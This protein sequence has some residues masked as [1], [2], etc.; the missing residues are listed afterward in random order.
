MAGPRLRV[1]S[2]SYMGATDPEAL[3]RLLRLPN[4]E[5]RVSYDTKRT[6]LHAKAYLVHRATNFG[7]AYVGSAN[8]SHAALSEG[9]EWTTKISHRELPHLWA[10]TT[11]T[12]ETYW[13]DREFQ[14]LAEEGLPRLK[15]S[16]VAERGGTDGRS[17][18]VR[19]LRPPPVPLSR[20]DPRHPSP[21]SGRTGTSTATS[22][23]RPPA[24]ARPSSPPL[25]TAGSVKSTPAPP[26]PACS[27]SPTAAR[28]LTRPA[29]PSAPCSATTTSA[30]R[31]PAA[32]PSRRGTTCFPRSRASTAA[33]SRI[34]R[35]STSPTSSST[36]STTPRPPPTPSCS[37]R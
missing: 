23:S 13:N 5:V 28:S 16:I 26:A 25:T 1:I 9:L 4:A 27:S 21:P 14:P 32:R 3:A 17:G 22:S 8:L 10:R 33:A 2:T 24:P 6:R 19:P 35:P 36:S 18:V 31:S 29:T 11:G 20:R 12:F 30:T 34:C 7:S 15:A 37:T